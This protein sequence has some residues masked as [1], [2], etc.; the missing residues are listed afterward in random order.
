MWASDRP[1]NYYQN[2]NDII[3]D[4]KV[5]NYFVTAVNAFSKIPE[6]KTTPIA[7]IKIPKVF[8]TVICSF[9]KI[10]PPTKAKMGVNAPNAAV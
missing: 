2:E 5:N 7:T 6:A 9:K 8:I 3:K 1:Q 10:N 4:E